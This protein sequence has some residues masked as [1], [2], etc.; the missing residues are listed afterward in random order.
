MSGL[1]TC[2]C[3]HEC[4]QHGNSARL[5]LNM[6]VGAGKCQ[7]CDCK[8]WASPRN[9]TENSMSPPPPHS[10]SPIGSLSENRTQ[11][12]S[13]SLSENQNSFRPDKPFVGFRGWRISKGG[14]LPV[15]HHEDGEWASREPTHARCM[16]NAKHKAA[17][18]D[19][20][21]GLWAMWRLA[22]VIYHGTYG[23]PYV[24]GAIL[25]WG[26]V[27][28]HGAEGFRAEYAQVV[29][30]ALQLPPPVIS[31][32]LTLDPGPCE[33]HRT[34]IKRIAGLLDVPVLSPNEL[35]AFALR[36]GV[37]YEALVSA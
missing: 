13:G 29:G 10:S 14:L 26:R 31:L 36:Q 28:R 15:V 2:A 7:E 9:V 32:G 37:S 23:E 34:E 1:P 17:E 6:G 22:S 21:C 30:L 16:V 12:Q 27:Q 20:H 5:W 24:A 18:P 33:A 25:G 19:C 8:K 3:G 4:Y 11:S 35:E